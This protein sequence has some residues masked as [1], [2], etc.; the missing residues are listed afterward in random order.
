MRPADDEKIIMKADYKH[1][2]LWHFPAS[3]DLLG[4][5]RVLAWLQVN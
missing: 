4:S 2:F 3:L 1:T 5:R